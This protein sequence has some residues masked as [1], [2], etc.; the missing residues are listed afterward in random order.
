M[1]NVLNTSKNAW[2]PCGKTLWILK[3]FDKG[4]VRVQ[5]ETK[6]RSRSFWRSTCKH[7]GQTGNEQKENSDAN[8]TKSNGTESICSDHK[9][10]EAIRLSDQ[11]IKENFEAALCYQLSRTAEWRDKAVSD[12]MIAY[13]VSM[14]RDNTKSKEE[15]LPE[16]ESLKER[17]IIL[18]EEIRD[19][20]SLKQGDVAAWLSVIQHG[21]KVSLAQ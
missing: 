12:K 14:C 13:L 18:G 6:A 17:V 7:F 5:L 1:S 21:N 8:F 20:G 2:I 9:L 19:V 11:Y 15:L 4:V 10:S 3:L 16:V